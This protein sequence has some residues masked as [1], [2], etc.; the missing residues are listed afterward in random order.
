MRLLPDD[1]CV[2]GSR[3]DAP[4]SCSDH[5]S[6][7]AGDELEVPAQFGL[8]PRRTEGGVARNEIVLCLHDE[9]GDHALGQGSDLLQCAGRE[10]SYTRAPLS[11][12]GRPERTVPLGLA[13]FAAVMRRVGHAVVCWRMRRVRFGH[14]HVHCRRAR[15]G[16]DRL[17]KGEGQ[18]QEGENPGDQARASL[19]EPFTV[20]RSYGTVHPCAC[21]GRAAGRPHTSATNGDVAQA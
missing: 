2:S 20:N 18:S 16:Q 1:T 7:C 9:H 13:I 17:R 3:Q 5:V 6:Y 14:L 11:C 19:H 15:R 10:R 12:G 21:S 4:A 8:R